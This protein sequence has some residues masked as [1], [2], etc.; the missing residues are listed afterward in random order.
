MN[1]RRREYIANLTNEC[2]ETLGKGTHRT[3]D[4]KDIHELT[5]I[6]AELFQEI[7]D[8]QTSNE[9]L[10]KLSDDVWAVAKKLEGTD[11]SNELKKISSYLH[12]IR[13]GRST[14][15]YKTFEVKEK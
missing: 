4:R 1:K 2:I 12:D 11:E 6:I 15:W 7:D 10:P 8:M 5:Q 13:T 3:I 14:E 9:L